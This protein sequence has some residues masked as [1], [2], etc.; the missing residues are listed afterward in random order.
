M[1]RFQGKKSDTV[2]EKNEKKRKKKKKCKSEKVKKS[3][4]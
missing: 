3:D 2:R 4:K 1:I